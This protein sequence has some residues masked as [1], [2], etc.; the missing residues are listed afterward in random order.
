MA[1]LHAADAPAALA[2]DLAE[3]HCEPEILDTL[4]ETSSEAK[5][6]RRDLRRLNALMGNT[7]WFRRTL[8]RVARRGERVLELGAGG[9]ELGCS[10]ARLGWRVD[11]IDLAPRPACWPPIGNWHQVDML[12]L[13][14]W[15]VA[16]VVV[17]NLILHHFEPL[18][19]AALGEQLDRH[20]RVIVAS[21]P[22][23]RRLSH[24]LFSCACGLIRAHDYTRHDGALSINAGFR[25]EELPLALGLDPARWN[26]SITTHFLGAYRVVAERRA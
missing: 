22:W 6:C 12:T 5:H 2:R 9:G 7:R 10:L 21:E 25:G 16:P 18:E 3:R 17:A 20:A 11:G 26:W 23:R 1:H 15:P 14:C 8:T 24:R 13:K 19:L 4:P